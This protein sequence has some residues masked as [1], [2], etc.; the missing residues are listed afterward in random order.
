MTAGALRRTPVAVVVLGAAI[1]LRLA[2]DP[3]LALGT[4]LSGAAGAV[5]VA[6]VFVIGSLLAMVLRAA[7]LVRPGARAIAGLPR[8]ELPVDVRSV[9]RRAGVVRL[10]GIEGTDC[11]AFCAGLLRPHVYL[12]S[13]A[14]DTLSR[15]ELEAVLVHEA[16]HARR[17]DPLRRLVARS[18]ADVWL[19]L[20]V[21]RWWAARRMEHA[22]LVADR[23]ALARTDPDAVAGA[24]WAAAGGPPDTSQNESAFDDAVQ[25]RLARLLD[26]P[27]PGRG[28]APLTVLGSVAGLLGMI[29]L[30]MFLG[31]GMLLRA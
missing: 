15:R 28:L 18:V 17:R 21:L 24:L 25:T 12:T 19:F 4:D 27:A 10:V 8:V 26:E 16:T 31:P 14:V 23:A 1:A 29:A 22:E 30:T 3:A 6:S 9:A 11:T 5:L 20:P 13:G 2:W 7:S